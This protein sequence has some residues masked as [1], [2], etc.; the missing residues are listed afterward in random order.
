MDRIVGCL[1]K[2]TGMQVRLATEGDREYFAGV[3]RALDSGI[4]I[5]ADYAPF[6]RISETATPP[7]DRLIQQ[8]DDYVRDAAGRRQLGN[9]AYCCS[10]LLEYPD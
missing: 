1:G 6:V 9:R 3:I 10:A 7:R 4:Q 5:H 8:A 2:A